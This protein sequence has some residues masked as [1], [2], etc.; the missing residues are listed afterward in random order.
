MGRRQPGLE[1]RT[2][3]T[4]W[5]CPLRQLLNFKDSYCYFFVCEC[6]LCLPCLQHVSE[7]RIRSLQ[8]EF[9]AAVSCHVAAR[10]RTQVLYLSNKCF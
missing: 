5:E 6:F 2:H 4:Q 10:N 9:Q 1:V 3:G 7:E 8:L